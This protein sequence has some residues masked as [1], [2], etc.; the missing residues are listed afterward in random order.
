[1]PA[2]FADDA[3]ERKEIAR[4]AI[5]RARIHH[6]QQFDRIILVGDSDGDVTTAAR[7]GLAFVGIAA[8]GKDAVPRAAAA[9]LVLSDYEDFATFMR[10]VE[11]ASP[12][13]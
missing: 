3:A 13:A 10:T 2:A 9:Q 11:I 4:I 5:A 6:Q 7:L 1:M 8:D 12:G